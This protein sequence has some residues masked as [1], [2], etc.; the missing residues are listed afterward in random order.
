MSF[1]RFSES[2]FRD[3]C[4]FQYLKWRSSHDPK[5]YVRTTFTREPSTTLEIKLLRP[6]SCYFVRFWKCSEK[7][8]KFRKQKKSEISENFKWSQNLIKKTWKY[9][10]LASFIDT[11]QWLKFKETWG[12]S[13]QIIIEFGWNDPKPKQINRAF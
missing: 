1:F 5:V 12:P 13:R 8:Q 3:M 11:R 4:F 10:R 7:I 6:Q 2:S 9:S